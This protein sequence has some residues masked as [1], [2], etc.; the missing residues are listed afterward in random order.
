MTHAHVSSSPKQPP[1]AIEAKPNRWALS[2]WARWFRVLGR[3]WLVT[4]HARR[5]C[6]PL[7]IEGDENFL[8]LPATSIP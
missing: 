5:F 7:R 1:A 2:L 3:R 4:R 8:H 6:H